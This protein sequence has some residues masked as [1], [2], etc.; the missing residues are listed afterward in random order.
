M[1]YQLKSERHKNVRFFDDHIL[2][3][4]TR[5]SYCF[6]DAFIELFKENQGLHR[7]D[8]RIK[9]LSACDIIGR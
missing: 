7:T 9:Q 8:C 4:F 3:Y 5:I 2:N 6:N 1:H